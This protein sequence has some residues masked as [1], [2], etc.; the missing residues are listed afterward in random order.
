VSKVDYTETADPSTISTIDYGG[1]S[2]ET[3]DIAMTDDG[4]I[5]FVL[6]RYPVDLVNACRVIFINTAGNYVT[7]AIN[8]GQF[9]PLS[10]VYKKP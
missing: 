7:G 6:V 2:N 3:M 8:V 9:E 5:V 10:I 1:T 4:S